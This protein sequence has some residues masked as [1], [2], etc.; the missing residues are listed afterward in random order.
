MYI[1]IFFY[2]W[3]L[4]INPCE[5]NTAV[6]AKMKFQQYIFGDRFVMD[7][8]SVERLQE[9]V[10]AQFPELTVIWNNH[11][12]TLCSMFIWHILFNLSAQHNRLQYNKPIV[13]GILING[14]SAKHFAKELNIKAHTRILLR[15]PYADRLSNTRSGSGQKYIC[16]SN[17]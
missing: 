13:S 17:W 15:R 12:C 14:P 7:G 5:T 8:A 11:M 9:D 10:L 6:S 2:T 16:C 1:N 3:M 4:M